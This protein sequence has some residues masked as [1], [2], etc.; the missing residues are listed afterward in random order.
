MNKIYAMHIT[1]EIKARS[2]ESALKKLEP[3]KNRKKYKVVKIE[4]ANAYRK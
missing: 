2:L 3:L 1:I 4:Y